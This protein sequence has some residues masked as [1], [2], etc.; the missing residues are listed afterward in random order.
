VR[1]SSPVSRAF[2][3]VALLALALIVVYPLLWMVFLS[4]KN[5]REMYTHVWGPPHVFEWSNYPLAWTVGNV[6]L[7]LYNTFLLTAV[8][9]VL[10]LVLCYFAAYAQ[11]RIRFPGSN[12]IMVILVGTMLLPAQVIIIPLYTLESSLGILNSRLGLILPYVAG[13]IPFS[14]FLLTA[15]LK[16]IPFEL[17]E[18]AFVDGCRRTT[19]IRSIILPLSRPGLATIIVFQSFSVWNQYFL[20]LVL[21]QSPSLQTVTL[22]LMAFSQQWG[23]TDFP[24]LF[25][26]LVI[27]NVP[28]IALYAVFQKQFISGLTAGA[29]KL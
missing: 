9:I 26:A 6:G 27:I 23:A 22:G 20:P 2:V 14:I 10:I 29:L 4:L 13:G 21:L 1:R 17:E 19:I 8:S 12:L 28:V 24:R 5:Q 15:F 3:H 7:T 11:A 18:S 25:A 16:T